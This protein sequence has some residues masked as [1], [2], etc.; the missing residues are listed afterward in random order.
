ML[1]KQ[2]GGNGMGIHMNTPRLIIQKALSTLKF[3]KSA[4][5]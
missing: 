1:I 2:K 5:G 4:A 3:F